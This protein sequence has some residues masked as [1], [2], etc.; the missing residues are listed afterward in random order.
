M[1]PLHAAVAAVVC[2]LLPAASWLDGTG[3]LA[4]TM[5]S[6]SASYRLEI[7]AISADG[8]RYPLAP[9]A[10]ARYVGRDEAPAFVA[11]DTWRMMSS[12]GLR[13]RLEEAGA[14]ACR[15]RPARQVEIT[16]FTRRSLDAA[17]ESRTTRVPCDG[18]AP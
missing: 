4:W 6:G 9:T 11:A 18:S 14:L 16:L 3:F 5:Y 8:L 17:A 1:R 7:V 10:L 12:R 13:L 2:V 15:L